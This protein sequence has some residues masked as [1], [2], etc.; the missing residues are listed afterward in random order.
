MI[1][2]TSYGAYIPRLRLDRMSI[3][4]GMGWFAP[5]IMMV[6]QGERSMC[7]WDEDTLTM[8]V[9]ASR[10]CLKGMDKHALDGLYLAS[11]TLPFADRQ[12]AGI[13]SAALNLNSNLI[14]SDFAASQKAGSTALIT[15]LES[16]KSGDRKSILVAAS[17]SRETRTAY[18][19]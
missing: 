6:A 14:T 5:A 10:D 3:F 19:Y 4:Q 9:A 8:A 13:V 11:T 12:N 16:V 18:F 17:D 15:A 1:G 7:N 2:I